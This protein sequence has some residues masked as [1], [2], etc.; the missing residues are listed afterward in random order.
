MGSI[1]GGSGVDVLDF[2]ART[3]TIEVRLGTLSIVTNIAEAYSAIEQIHGNSLPLSKII[4]TDS[5]TS[6]TMNTLGSVLVNRSEF[7]GFRRVEAGAGL[8]TLTGPALSSV[9]TID[10]LNGGTL[11]FGLSSLSFSG[12]ENVGGNTFDDS[13]EILP[14]GSL[15]GNLSGGAGTGFD[16]ISY[17]AWVDGVQIDLS[18]PSTT[19]GNATG[20][21]GH[22]SGF[23]LVS[24]G[25]GNDSLIAQASVATILLG[26]AGN[27]LLRGGTGRDFLIGGE[28]ADN[29]QG[30]GGE[31]LLISGAT[32]HD[33]DRS[34]LVAIR[35]EW[36]T[37]ARNFATRVANLRGQGTGASL[38]GSYLLNS[39]SI[40]DDAETEDLLTGG[41]N[42]DWFWSE[43]DEIVD[44]ITSGNSPDRFR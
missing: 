6:W 28:G 16:S 11:D 36:T 40:F 29:L 14:T 39:E 4:G 43:L 12:I 5:P 35:N 19:L 3:D 21:L 37:S 44:L 30:L 38:N 24:G 32:L 26:R 1:N 27:D 2:S 10:S 9:W 42:Q 15:L 33:S 22:T 41:T 34:A 18:R 23:E 20:I 25:A 8:D 31:D 13:F 7:R 17:G